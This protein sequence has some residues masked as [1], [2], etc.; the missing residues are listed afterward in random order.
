MSTTERDEKLGNGELKNPDFRRG[1]KLM[2]SAIWSSDPEVKSRAADE[3]E[4]FGSSVLQRFA[5][6]IRGREK[7]SPIIFT[8]PFDYR[9]VRSLKLEISGRSVLCDPV[10]RAPAIQAV[11]GFLNDSECN[12]LISL[13]LPLLRRSQ[14]F[15]ASSDKLIN[16][17]RTSYSATISKSENALTLDISNR[18]AQLCNTSVDCLEELQVTRY[19]PGQEFVAHHDFFPPALANVHSS[20]DNGGQRLQTLLVF[21]NNLDPDDPGGATWF[22]RI[23]LAVKCEQGSGLLWNNV[24]AHGEL[25]DMTLHQGVA[26]KTSTKFVLSVWIRERA[27]SKKDSPPWQSSAI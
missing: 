14:S 8:E 11:R 6:G 21:L 16:D 26:P 1:M 17:V 20:L 3:F 18:V 12:D 25:D 27:L 15:T 23:N 19:E 10:C 5:Q 2:L 13:S 22:P 24:T 9:I 4:Q 7:A